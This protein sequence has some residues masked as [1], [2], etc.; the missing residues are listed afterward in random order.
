MTHPPSFSDEIQNYSL[1]L[2]EAMFFVEIKPYTFS[3]RA[4]AAGVPLPLPPGCQGL[5]YIPFK[6]TLAK[7]D[8]NDLLAELEQQLS[9]DQWEPVPERVE[10]WSSLLDLLKQR[11][12]LKTVLTPPEELEAQIQMQPLGDRPP[13]LVAAEKPK[14][15][16]DADAFRE[17]VEELLPREARI[18]LDAGLVLAGGF[19]G[20]IGAW[21]AGL[22]DKPP[23]A[24]AKKATCDIDFFPLGTPEEALQS[25]RRALI[26]LAKDCESTETGMFVVRS[27]HALTIGM[28]DCCFDLQIVLCT[29][30]TPAD[31]LAKFDIDASR[32]A[33]TPTRQL[34][35]SETAIRALLSGALLPCSY[36]RHRCSLTTPPPHQPAPTPHRHP[37]HRFR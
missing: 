33:Y 9:H 19:L 13:G 17:A 35:A 27:P 28:D 14:L 31:I 32:L 21:L 8:V 11:P 20:R 16:R 5:R 37:C 22:C 4:R 30:E 3:Q 34:I 24:D 36:P 6:G 23:T 12:D 10:L 7:A 18:L 15:F 26:A 2:D 25:V 29:A 1:V